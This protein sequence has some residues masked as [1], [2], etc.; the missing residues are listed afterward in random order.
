MPSP[1]KQTP[2]IKQM[3]PLQHQRTRH[4]RTRSPAPSLLHPRETSHPRGTLPPRRSQKFLDPTQRI[5]FEEIRALGPIDAKLLLEMLP[6]RVTNRGFPDFDLD[7]LLHPNLVSEEDIEKLFQSALR[8]IDVDE[9]G[10]DTPE[11]IPLS[12]RAIW[13]AARHQSFS[14]V[15]GLDYN[16]HPDPTAT[17]PLSPPTL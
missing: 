3:T 16:L 14:M 12:P 8:L 10:D 13:A 1:L 7:E 5:V 2:A 9:A 17:P 4:R 15:R 6:A 11:T